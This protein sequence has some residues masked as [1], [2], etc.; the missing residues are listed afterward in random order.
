MP[1]VT[2]PQRKQVM[3]CSKPL[4]PHLLLLPGDRSWCLSCFTHGL[5]RS[6]RNCFRKVLQPLQAA[7]LL[8]VRE[9]IREGKAASWAD[10]IKIRLK[11]GCL[12][13]KLQEQQSSPPP[14]PLYSSTLWRKLG[15]FNVKSSLETNH[16]HTSDTIHIYLKTTIHFF[17]FYCDS[18]LQLGSYMIFVLIPQNTITKVTLLYVCLPLFLSFLLFVVISIQWLVLWYLRKRERVFKDIIVIRIST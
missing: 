6:Q 13:V 17:H 14:P 8:L 9:Y 5:H 11:A 3:S 16:T 15:D 2:H 12:R 18:L 4:L 10:G 7:L 1:T